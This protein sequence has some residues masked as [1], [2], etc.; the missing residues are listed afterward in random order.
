MYGP[1]NRDHRKNDGQLNILMDRFENMRKDYTTSY[2]A[3]PWRDE[4]DDPKDIERHAQ[5]RIWKLLRELD[6]MPMFLPH[7][8]R[9]LC[10]L[11]SFRSEVGA[12]EDE[13]A[14]QLSLARSI[15]LN[16]EALA[17]HI[18]K[19]KKCDKCETAE[20][21]AKETLSRFK[22]KNNKTAKAICNYIGKMLSIW[23]KEK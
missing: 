12:R 14:E 22:K 1:T 5:L 16:T 17:E 15:V 23:K 4:G 8:K 10:K 20:Q 6:V 13:L 19:S 7:L 11:L 21:Q 9:E 18:R 3:I 2:K